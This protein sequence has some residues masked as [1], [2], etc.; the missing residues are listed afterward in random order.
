[1]IDVLLFL[2]FLS[3]PVQ[4][5]K[6][7]F[8]EFSSLSG[9]RVDFLAPTLY[10]SDIIIFLLLCIFFSKKNSLPV[11]L[12][13]QKKNCFSLF[14]LFITSVLLST[15]PIRSFFFYIKII[16]V[17]LLGYVLFTLKL[18]F[19]KILLP[20]SI[21]LVYSSIIGILQFVKQQSLGLWVLGERS[22]VGITPGIAKIDVNNS[23]FVRAYS[24]FPHPNVFGGFLAVILTLI[25]CW[26]YQN[27]QNTRVKSSQIL[28]FSCSYLLGLVALFFT[29]SFSAW[30]VYI[31]GTVLVYLNASKKDSKTTIMI[32]CAISLFFLQT[33]I[34]YQSSTISEDVSLRGQLN[35]TAILQWKSHPVFGVGLNNFIAHIQDVSMTV[36]RPFWWQ[37]VHNVYLLLLSETGIVGGGLFVFFIWKII[38]RIRKVSGQNRMFIIPFIQI[39]LLGIVDHYLFTLQQGIL[40]LTLSVVLVFL[41]ENFYTRNIQ[42]KS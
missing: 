18:K 31:L 42:K 10:F 8:L 25:T 17:F 33:V 32:V 22:I 13:T 3:F 29:F 36:R 7:F 14:I 2:L 40:L 28:F 38:K 23:V 37:P 9:I 5:G 15:L 11:F 6:H 19:K 39:L 27:P 4:L 34:K 24:T 16:E 26:F 12:K 41:N 20:L 21:A 1:M 30:V 35:E